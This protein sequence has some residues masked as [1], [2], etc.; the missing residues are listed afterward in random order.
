MDS[1]DNQ[2][3]NAESIDDD[4]VEHQTKK[5]HRGRRDHS[6]NVEF[7]AVPETTDADNDIS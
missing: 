5:K 1:S 4:T 3:F 7:S 2:S 6:S